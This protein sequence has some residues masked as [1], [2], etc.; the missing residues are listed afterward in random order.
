MIH[1]VHYVCIIIFIIHVYQNTKQK[2]EI[3][4]SRRN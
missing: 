4:F 1:D 2:L 3:S